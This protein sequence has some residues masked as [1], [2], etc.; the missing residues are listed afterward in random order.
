MSRRA[1]LLLVLLPLSLSACAAD[2]T[3]SRTPASAS[4]GS[5]PGP[6]TSTTAQT[7]PTPPSR[8]VV[9]EANI[10]LR[11]EDPEAVLG[12]AR[13]WTE[14]HGGFVESS[15][16]TGAGNE[17]SAARATFRF[18]ADE[19]D[20]ALLHFRTLGEVLESGERGEDVTEQVLDLDARLEAKRELE[21]R[22]ITLVERATRVAELLEV[23]TELG[24]VRGDIESMV[25]VRRSLADRVALATIH[26]D[27]EAPEQPLVEDAE[28]FASVL[29][30]ACRRGGAVASNV[31]A[32]SI[33]LLV[34]TSP[35]LALFLVLSR[36]RRTSRR[37]HAAA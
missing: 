19:L 22:L 12:A 27:V 33:V 2:D 9:R 24:R 23:E 16:A 11:G 4:S 13:R 7:S 18:P 34:G 14:T 29:D 35:L 36:L 30:N 6:T 37:R 1:P 5:T 32:G 25:A 8:S 26:L 31:V 21:R 17:R 10:R 15:T 28:S 3:P 20:E